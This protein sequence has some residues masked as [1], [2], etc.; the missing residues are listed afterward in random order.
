MLKNT[1]RILSICSNTYNKVSD[2]IIKYAF[3]VNAIMAIFVL[4]TVLWSLNKG[5]VFADESFYLLH[6]QQP[7]GVVSFSEWPFYAQL[8]F[9]KDL[10]TI[11]LI[12]IFLQLL[13]IGILSFSINRFFK[14]IPF[15]EILS[16]G[17]IGMFVFFS[18]VQFVPNYVT[19]N[20][21][22]ITLSTGFFLLMLQAEEK[23]QKYI[24]GILTGFSIGP[25]IFIMVTNIPFICLMS[26]IV[27]VYSKKD[28]IVQLLSITIGI[29]LSV[30]FFFVFVR[31][32]NNY[33]ND[34]NMALDYLATD[35]SH[36]NSS[37]VDWV[38]DV[39]LYALKSIIPAALLFFVSLNLFKNKPI[40]YFLFSI[41]ILIMLFD[42]RS[43]FLDD[44]KNINT[45]T[46]VFIIL[47]A[48][49]LNAF[50]NKKFQLASILIFALFIPFFSSLGTDVSYI[51]RSTMYLVTPFVLIFC[52]LKTQEN[53]KFILPFYLLISLF[54]FR[55]K[56]LFPTNTGWHNF[57]LSDQT[58]SV[59]SIGINQNIKLD[60]PK[61]E[62][63]K[64]L[65]SIIPIN[66]KLAVSN[67]TLWGNAFL[68]SL[69][70]L[71]LSYVFDEKNTIKALKELT[72]KKETVYL[73]EDIYSPFPK[74]F[75]LKIDSLNYINTSS[76]ID[77]ETRL[78]KI[79]K[80]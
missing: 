63:L 21:I 58:I 71:Y 62:R 8:I 13:S 72:D 37:M 30:L 19:F 68:L 41:A 43:N 4:Y 61:I 65:K 48:I 7:N 57:K 11:R 64:K 17:I 34:L 26:F 45:P 22:L 5:L 67:N 1:N 44:I 55:H 73:L 35:Q 70:P 15:F 74:S 2:F 39:I 9:P 33:L 80:K 77:K 20:S 56:I 6:L 50:F 40:K 25:L 3:Y 42:I 46:P 79:N 10:F 49:T 47:L 66:S 16:I 51:I 69:N 78:Y 31:T 60:Q 53:K 32:Y 12:T 18:P 54:L 28:K 36:G 52:L 76:S 75:F 29:V 23:R 27:L 14:T 24:F 38:I 59:K